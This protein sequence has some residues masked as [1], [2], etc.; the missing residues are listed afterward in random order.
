M[1]TGSPHLRQTFGGC[2]AIPDMRSAGGGSSRLSCGEKLSAVS[3]AAAWHLAS[4]N[5]SRM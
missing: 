2:T 4:A 5:S 1:A 3:L